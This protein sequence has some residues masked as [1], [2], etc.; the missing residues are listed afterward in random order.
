MTFD[1]YRLIKY[2]LY[3]LQMENYELGRFWQLLFGRGWFPK[4]ERRKNLVW[5]GKAVLLFIL[6]E[7]FILAAALVLLLKGFYTPY[8]LW[9]QKAFTFLVVVYILDFFTPVFLTAAVLILWPFDFTAKQIIVGR[10]KSKIKNQKS[11]IKII[12]IAG[13]YG[14]T[15]MKE[16][17]KE[18]LGSK[19][20]VLAAPDSINTPVGIA[21]WI[22]DKVEASAEILIVEMGEHYRGD[23]RE[24][25]G[26]AKPDIAVVTGINQSHLERFKTMENLTATIFEIVSCAGPGAK[27]LVNGDDKNVTA[28]YKKFASP[29]REVTEYQASNI[30]HPAFNAEKLAWDFEL[31]GVG[32]TSVDLL[33]GYALGNIDAAAKISRELG[34]TGEQI[35]AGIAKIKPV[36]HRLQPLKGAGDVLIIDDAYNGNP[37]GAAEAIK[38]LSRFSGRRKVYITP[39]LV[40]M[41][42]ESADIHRAIGRQLAEVA[43]VVV[44]I[45]N[46]VTPW[47]E[48]GV[49]AGNRKPEAGSRILWFATAQEAH[50]SL[51]NILKPGDVVVFQNDWG[52][53]YL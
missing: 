27:I 5:T 44:L 42:S 18:V 47:I 16:V 39:G 2:H 31:D 52:D 35:K 34:M 22:S 53:N 40:E 6:A 3:L 38:V 30:K 14:K 43:D 33:G 32:R 48:E 9:W 41:G 51:R 50:S 21:R 15:T 26:I 1:P 20:K 4:K 12:G 29:D 7:I 19:F 11:K 49:K 17:L 8:A 46:S 28:G 37:D 45:K 24:I 10:A 13:S 23:I 36:E 25:C